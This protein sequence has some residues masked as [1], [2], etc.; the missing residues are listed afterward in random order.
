MLKERFSQDARPYRTEKGPKSVIEK[1]LF[2]NIGRTVNGNKIG[3]TQVIRPS[4]EDAVTRI[5]LTLALCTAMGCTIIS[6]AYNGAVADVTTRN[7]I[8]A[9]AVAAAVACVSTVRIFIARERRTRKVR[10]TAAS[11]DVQIDETV[12]AHTALRALVYLTTWFAIVMGFWVASLW[13]MDI[14]STSSVDKELA[15]RRNVASSYDNNA[16]QYVP[17]KC[18]SQINFIMIVFVGIVWTAYTTSVNRGSISLIG[19]LQALAAQYSSLDV[20]TVGHQQIVSWLSA[21][22]SQFFRVAY[23]LAE[24]SHHVLGIVGVF[25]YG[26]M[27]GPRESE[28]WWTVCLV[29]VMTIVMWLLMYVTFTEQD[30]TPMVTRLL[31]RNPVDLKS[32]KLIAVTITAMLIGVI[33]IGLVIAMSVTHA[34]AGRFDVLVW[35]VFLAGVVYGIHSIAALVSAV[36]MWIV[37]ARKRVRTPLTEIVSI[38]GASD[39]NVYNNLHH[40]VMAH[41]LSMFWVSGFLSASA[42]VF[43]HQWYM[44]WETVSYSL[45][46][47]TEF[48]VSFVTQ[49]GIQ[50]LAMFAGVVLMFF[51]IH[52]GYFLETNLPVYKPISTSGADDKQADLNR[53]VRKRL[54]ANDIE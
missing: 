36:G 18:T 46:T 21:T 37:A 39:Y 5:V 35:A 26:V 45:T 30:Q 28:T 31:K 19:T 44:P 11:S 14:Y 16:S 38:E 22:E 10:A 50:S 29:G 43:L 3:E 51:N 52:T 49:A 13:T 42:F 17:F 24:S 54:H 53:R 32:D 20:Q 23:Y 40:R 6:L 34:E 47:N 25:F 33:G 41:T 7:L 8:L 1:R 9:A 12:G 27:A 2:D 15:G 48:F 4:L